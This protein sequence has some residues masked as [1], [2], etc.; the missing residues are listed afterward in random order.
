MNIS[1]QYK[2]KRRL[3]AIMRNVKLLQGLKVSFAYHLGLTDIPKK[4]QK[5][6]FT[7]FNF[8]LFTTIPGVFI[9]T[10]FFRQD[11]RISTVAIYN[12]V[13]CFGSAVVMHLSSQISLKKSPVFVLRIGVAFFNI[14]YIALLLLQNNAAKYMLL[15]GVLNAVASGFYWQGYNEMVKLCTNESIF[16]R[17]VS[18]IGLS[19]AV[20]TLVVPIVSGV[21]DN[22]LF[23]PAWL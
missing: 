19:S 2:A 16:D 9:N 11:G 17:T 15:L 13:A 23:R 1:L 21:S 10:F 22:S 5:F 8:V 3:T 12:G 14:F 7:H 4:T 20:V 6:I 18:L